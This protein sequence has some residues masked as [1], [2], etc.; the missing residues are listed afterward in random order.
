MTDPETLDDMLS[1][2]E[3]TIGAALSQRNHPARNISFCT[4]TPN[5]PQARIVVLR[6]WKDA[7]ALVQTDAASQKVNELRADNR[8]ALLIWSP[9]L[10]LQV[11]L[12]CLVEM[13]IGDRD[14]WAAVPPPARLNYGGTPHPGAPMATAEEYVPGTDPA[15]LAVLSCQAQEMEVLHLGQNMHRRARFNWTEAVWKGGWVAP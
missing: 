5:G 6:G 4:M 1:M 11:R 7:V 15:R 10:N 13:D 12:R 8:A 9:R 3:G 14:K 2:V